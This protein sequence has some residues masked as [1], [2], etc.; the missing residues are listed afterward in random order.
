[1]TTCRPGPVKPKLSTKW[2]NGTIEIYSDNSTLT[3]D[4]EGGC[5]LTEAATRYSLLEPCDL[6][7]KVVEFKRPQDENAPS[8]GGG[9]RVD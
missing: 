1:M 9:D 2:G 7:K 3:W 5:M 4:G 8:H 6:S